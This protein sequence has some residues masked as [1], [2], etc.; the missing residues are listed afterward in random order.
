MG[1][2]SLPLPHRMA[3]LIPLFL[4]EAEG[5]HD[6]LDVFRIRL[7]ELGEILVVLVGEIEADFLGEILELLG[8]EGLLEGIGEDGLDRGI[9]LLGKG[10]P[11]PGIE[12]DVDALL[13][14]RRNVREEGMRVSCP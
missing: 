11:A 14:E 10:E 9:H 5:F 13:P 8:I 2:K 6:R 3:F 4:R 7:Q 1:Q 12:G